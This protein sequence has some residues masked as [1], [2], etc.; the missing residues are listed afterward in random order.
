MKGLSF[1]KKIEEEPFYNKFEIQQ[2]GK[3]AGLSGILYLLN[4]EM[5][6]AQ[7]NLLKSINM[8]NSSANFL[9]NFY[10]KT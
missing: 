8:T 2:Q 5:D 9:G 10:F 7:Y 4:N 1:S 6:K 3:L